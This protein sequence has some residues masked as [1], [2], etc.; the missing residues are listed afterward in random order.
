MMGRRTLSRVGLAV[1]VSA[2]ILGT[3]ASLWA[4]PSAKY[5]DGTSTGDRPTQLPLNAGRMLQVPPPEAGVA[6]RA[7]RMFDANAGTMVTDRV[8]LIQGERI[9][10][11][12]PSASVKIPPGARVIDLSKA[13]VL[14]GLI[15]AH[16]HF[17]EVEPNITGGA[18]VGLNNVQA[19]LQGGFTTIVDLGSDTYNAVNLRDGINAGTI[20]GPRMQVA[21]VRMNNR[22]GGPVPAPD[23]YAMFGTRPDGSVM[24]PNARGI[25][26]VESAR[27][28]V[29][30]NRW[31]GTDWIKVLGTEDFVGGGRRGAFHPDGRMI[32]V[33]SL[34][35]EE[36]RA[37]GDE[38]RRSGLK[39]T[40]H[41]YGGEGL[42]NAL[43]A[44]IDVPMHSEV[45]VTG[46]V[47]LDEETI[48]LWQRPLP[49]GEP[50]PVLQ[51][52]FDLV[53][54]M[55]VRD[56]A[57][58]GGK[59]SR[60]QITEPSFKR[61]V[62]AGV[63]QVF[64]TGIYGG[65]YGTQAMQF[66]YYIKWGMAPGEALKMSSMNA[67]KVLNYDWD[68]HVGSIEKGKFADIVAVAGDPMTDIT[69]MQRVK[70]VMKGGVIHRDDF[71][72]PTPPISSAQK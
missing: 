34:T 58:T 35:Q 24:W 5:P 29:R 11:V 71:T 43:M 23:H 3:S 30:E 25:K 28:A 47:G 9:T 60:L 38:A 54:G 72:T 64:G 70:F 68:N 14:P 63:M 61:L 50:R 53:E 59:A 4:Q 18:Y 36:F 69:E 39:S 56:L 26:G 15:D 62:A 19:A 40:A 41:V 46:Q 13:T 33:P 1:L 12:G 20:V 42:R 44:D 8:I 66:P 37:I 67:A 21:G 65:Y 2:G 31:Y 22:A 16:G 27:Q 49:N 17:T 10:D 48:K 45:G 57:T 7:G 32:I 6:I 55:E 52:I 51:T